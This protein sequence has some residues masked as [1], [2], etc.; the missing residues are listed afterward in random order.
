MVLDVSSQRVMSTDAVLGIDP[1]TV[2]CGLAVVTARDAPPLFRRIVASDQLAEEVRA[3]LASYPIAKI[4]LGG[5]TH[6]KAAH[7][8]LVSLGAA[9]GASVTI[10]DER[11]TTLR[12]RAR[13][14]AANPPRGW[15]AL[16]PRGLLVPA[17]PID[18]WAAVLIAERL[19]P[20]L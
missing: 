2:K 9:V 17:E 4:A 6:G 7:A 10:V 20:I 19:F 18:D 12:A 1:G 8:A 5:G 16:L 11:D 3:C 14:F 13:Y 15:R